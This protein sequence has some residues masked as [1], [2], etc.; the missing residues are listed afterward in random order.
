M[1][2]TFDPEKI[3]AGREWA[4]AEMRTQAIERAVKLH[5]LSWTESAEA[6]VWIATLHSPAG[7]HTI[8]LSYAALTKCVDSESERTMLRERLRHLIGDLARIERRG[9]LR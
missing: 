9:F 2:D 7:E 6:K 4:E 3:M 8:A 1:T 5:S